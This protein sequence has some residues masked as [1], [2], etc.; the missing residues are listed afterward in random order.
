METETRP[1][2]LGLFPEFREALVDA[3]EHDSF[4]REQDLALTL[5]ADARE[6]LKVAEEDDPMLMAN[7]ANRAKKIQKL[8]D[9]EHPTD[10][11]EPPRVYREEHPY[12]TMIQAGF[13]V[14][15][16]LAAMLMTIKIFG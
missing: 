3:A 15:L 6:A 12:L 7:L 10:F 13:A 5:V 16:G 11:Q 2:L 4:Q 8:Y 14:L 9:A 1:E